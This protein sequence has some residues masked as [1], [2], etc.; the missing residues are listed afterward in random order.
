MPDG[1]LVRVPHEIAHYGVHGSKKNKG[2]RGV[3]HMKLKSER[4][5]INKIK[6]DLDYY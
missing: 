5:Q 2:G 3:I 6:G 4:E 1:I